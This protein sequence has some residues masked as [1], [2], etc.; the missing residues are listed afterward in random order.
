MFVTFLRYLQDKAAVGIGAIK[1]RRVHRAAAGQDWI[2]I[3]SDPTKKR[4]A[5][6]G[7]GP[8]RCSRIEAANHE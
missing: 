7:I 2:A 5:L 8:T 6:R 1:T 3:V 4:S